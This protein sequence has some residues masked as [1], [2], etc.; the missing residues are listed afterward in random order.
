[1]MFLTNPMVSMS[2]VIEDGV[3][4]S[5]P[6]EQTK[7]IMVNCLKEIVENTQNFPRSAFIDG[8]VLESLSFSMRGLQSTVQIQAT[9]FAVIRNPIDSKCLKFI[10]IDGSVS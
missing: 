4:F 10:H 9:Y 3:Q 8:E 2:L 6:L 7:E 1:M 5:P